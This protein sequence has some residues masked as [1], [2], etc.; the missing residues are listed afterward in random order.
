MPVTNISD[1]RY[2]LIG[3]CALKG[4]EKQLLKSLW[5]DRFSEQMAFLAEVEPSDRALV[6]AQKIF[7]KINDAGYQNANGFEV[8][9]A[10]FVDLREALEKLQ[11]AGQYFCD[12][13][14][15]FAL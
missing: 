6:M 5:E 10:V 13:E 12:A 14:C 7:R 11:R 3:V 2:K 4:E 9:L 8:V 15:T 1:I